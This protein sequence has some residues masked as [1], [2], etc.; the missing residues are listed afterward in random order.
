MR[1]DTLA[2]MLA[3]S[4]V[5]PYARV[6]VLDDCNGLVAGSA[7]ERMGGMGTLWSVGLHTG[8]AS[9][10]EVCHWCAAVGVL[11]IC[12]EHVPQSWGTMYVIVHTRTQAYVN[13]DDSGVQLS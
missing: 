3:Y 7:A 5:G 12:K 1:V 4:N 13:T 6:L 2:A 9:A 10:A 11:F 8:K